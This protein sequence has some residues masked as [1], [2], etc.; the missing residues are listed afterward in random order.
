[1]ILVG[2]ELRVEYPVI[3]YSITFVGLVTDWGI[4]YLV[5]KE[6]NI[7]KDDI[8]RNLARAKHA[9]G[10][11]LSYPGDILSEEKLEDMDE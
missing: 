1:L 10:M 6:M 9:G 11:S 8:E 7:M 4:V 3:G 2:T 5:Y